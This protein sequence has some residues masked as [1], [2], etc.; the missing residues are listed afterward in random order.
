MKLK[1][2]IALGLAAFTMVA[3]AAGCGSNTANQKAAGDQLPKKITVQT[4]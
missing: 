1:R 4:A 3:F 2:L